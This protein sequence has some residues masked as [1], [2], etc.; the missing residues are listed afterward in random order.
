M[1]GKEPTEESK[2]RYIRRHEVSFNASEN[3]TQNIKLKNIED[4]T[5]LENQLNDKREQPEHTGSDCSLLVPKAGL[6]P[7]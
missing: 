4:Y 6:E 3:N 2:A 1:K 5:N 7:A